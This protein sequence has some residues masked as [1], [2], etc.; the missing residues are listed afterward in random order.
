MSLLVAG[1]FFFND[2]Q[3]FHSR[4][5]NYRYYIRKC[6][7]Q[8]ISL[9][10]QLAFKVQDCRKYQVIVAKSSFCQWSSIIQLVQLTYQFIHKNCRNI[11]SEVAEKELAQM[12]KKACNVSI[13][14]N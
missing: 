14:S 3:T 7:E 1:N 2:L 9:L 5:K 12:T 10:L 8:D 11:K 13:D 6:V 4:Q